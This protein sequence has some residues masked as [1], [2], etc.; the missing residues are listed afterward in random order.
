MTLRTNGQPG[1][2]RSF[3]GSFGLEIILAE[4]NLGEDGNRVISR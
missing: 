1:T 4:A 2:Q 3:T